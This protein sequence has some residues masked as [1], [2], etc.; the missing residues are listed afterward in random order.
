[1]AFVHAQHGAGCLISPSA[2]RTIDLSK[3]VLGPGPL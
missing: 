3:T 1:M 2:S